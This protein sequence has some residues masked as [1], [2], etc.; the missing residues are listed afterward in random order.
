MGTLLKCRR[1][2]IYYDH[3]NFTI[4][5]PRNTILWIRVSSVEVLSN[6][7]F[8]RSLT[9][10]SKG[11]LTG[12]LAGRALESALEPWHVEIILLRT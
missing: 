2:C 1:T 8:L 6:G 7:H 10:P 3:L 12:Y 9:E 4:S 11:T 5:H